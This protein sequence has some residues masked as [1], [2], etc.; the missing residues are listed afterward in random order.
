MAPFVKVVDALRDAVIE[1][2]SRPRVIVT[3]QLYQST[4]LPPTHLWHD[5]PSHVQRDE[6]M[7]A[8]LEYV[9][10]PLECEAIWPSTKV[11]TARLKKMEGK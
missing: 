6:A 2:T 10:F 4:L 8:A 5:W 11:V 3:R 1:A 7:Q 9:G